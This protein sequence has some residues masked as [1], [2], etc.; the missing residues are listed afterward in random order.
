[1]GLRQYGGGVPQQREALGATD[2]SASFTMADRINEAVASSECRLA[3]A[4]RAQA[5]LE[6]H[7][8]IEELLNLLQQF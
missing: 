7:P 5:I 3:A 4:R 2:R 1:M 8:E 6:Q